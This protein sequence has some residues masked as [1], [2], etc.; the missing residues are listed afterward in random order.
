MVNYAQLLD[1]DTSKLTTAATT[2]GSLGSALSSRGSEVSSVADIPSGM[3]DGADAQAAISLLNP[4]SGPLFDASD[5]F[6]QSQGILEDLAEGLEKAKSMLADAKGLA[7]GAGI[8]I[9][10]DGTVTTP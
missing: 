6:S 7:D 1:L 3:W 9:G 8:T 2:A 4:Q 10:A 5:A